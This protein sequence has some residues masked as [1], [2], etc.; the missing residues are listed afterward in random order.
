MKVPEQKPNAA[1]VPAATSKEKMQAPSKRKAFSDKMQKKKATLELIPA[2][3]AEQNQPV[4]APQLQKQNLGSVSTASDPELLAPVQRLADEIHVHIESSGGTEVR[5]QFDSKVFDG[6][7]VQIRKVDD[8]AIAITFTTGNENTSQ[9]LSKHLPALSSA[10]TSKGVP[11]A[12]I[13][14]E[15]TSGFDSD[16]SF[17]SS[18]DWNRRGPDGAGKQ[19][20]RQ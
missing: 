5:I 11:V 6:L 20:K 12:A 3:I 2:Q 16:Q 17:N 9:S 7:R 13:Q 8:G 14:F 19:R 18:R 4:I 15:T 1:T 10:L